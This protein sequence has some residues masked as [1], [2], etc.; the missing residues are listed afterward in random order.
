MED[1]IVDEVHRA[2]EQVLKE[3]GGTAGLFKHLRAM[4]RARAGKAKAR[5]RKPSKKPPR[6]NSTVTA[7][8]RPTRKKV[9]RVASA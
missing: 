6:T 8:S 2:F 4:D 7:A 5:R 3:C 1:P 9:R